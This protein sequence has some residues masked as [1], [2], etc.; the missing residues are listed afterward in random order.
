[1][2]TDDLIKSMPIF[3]TLSN[4]TCAAII[5]ILKNKGKLNAFQLAHI[6]MVTDTTI[7]T[8]IPVLRTHGI[9]NEHKEGGKLYYSLNTEFKDK[10][11]NMLDGYF[12]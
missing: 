12:N 4:Q 3:K 11:K 1:M 8:Y 6:I 5:S 9:I 2:K 7:R 10:L